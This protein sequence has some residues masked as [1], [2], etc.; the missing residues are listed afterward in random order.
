MLTHASNPAALQVDDHT[1]QVFFSPRNKDNQ[2][3]IASVML[4]MNS[5]SIVA[6]SSRVELEAG[7]AGDFDDSGLS[8]GCVMQHGGEDYLYYLG[9]NL[10]DKV[11]FRNSIGLAKRKS[12][13][14]SFKKVSEG[15]I[16]DRSLIDPLSLS[17]P[18]VILHD[19]RFKMWYGSHTKWGKGTDDMVH[20][21]KYAESADALNWKPTGIV[22]LQNDAVDYAFSR[23]C[24]LVDENGYRMWYS[25]RGGNYRIGYAEST[26]GKNWLRKD[27][28]AGI[29]PSSDGW[30]SE[31][32]CYSWVFT[33][34]NQEYMLYCG[35][36]Y[37]KTGFGLAVWQP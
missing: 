14:T 22:C 18:S 13:T 5:K 17:Y 10:S 36:G 27:N 25:H 24:V 30:D 9:W 11:P 3:C 7:K 37:G 35:N 16:L 26:D 6:S 19:N 21:M 31:M 33:Y 15:P 23:P 1:F 8:M 34:Q 2:A 28:M 12:G 4:D 20:V 32:T 29:E